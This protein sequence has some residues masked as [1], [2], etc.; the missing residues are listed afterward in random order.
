[1]YRLAIDTGGTFTD[2]C[3]LDE[4]N[5]EAYRCKV[6]ST[7]DDP[8]IAFAAGIKNIL[9]K[10]GVKSDAVSYLGHGTTVGTNSVLEGKGVKTGLVTTKGFRDLLELGR[11]KRPHLYDLQADKPKCLVPRHLRYE[12]EERLD[13]KG[14]VL[15]NL[16]K[17]TL[18]KAFRYFHKEAVEALAIVFLYSFK[19]PEHEK[20]AMRLANDFL[21]NGFLTASYEV[22]PE[23]REY[24]RTSTA[25]MNAFIGPKTASYLN[26]LFDRVKELKLPVEPYI[27]QGNGGIVEIVEA[28][29]F[30][31]RTLLSGPAAGVEGARFISE[32]VG[33]ENIITLDMGGTSTDIAIVSEGREPFISSGQIAGYPLTLPM[34]DISTIGSGG[35]SI[36]RIDSGGALI[37]G[38]ESAGADPGPACYDLGGEDPT[39]TDA[40]VVLGTLNPKALLNGEMQISYKKAFEAIGRIAEKLDTSVEKAAYSI[41]EIGCSNLIRQVYIS[42]A[43]RGLDPRDFTLV[44]FGGAGPLHGPKLAEEMGIKKTLIPTMPGNLSALGILVAD[45]RYEFSVTDIISVEGE[46]VHDIRSTIS[47]LLVQARSWFKKQAIHKDRR[48]IEICF[49]MR[50]VGQNHELIVYYPNSDISGIESNT[51][52]NLFQQKHEQTYGYAKKDGAIQIVNHRVIARGTVSKPS[53]PKRSKGDVNIE[54]A[55]KEY[56]FANI[57]GEEKVNVPVYDRQK[58]LPGHMVKGPAIIEQYDS[59]TYIETERNMSIDNYSNIIIE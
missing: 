49:D 31:V 51:L 45:V 23:F 43:E 1:M 7:P 59:T 29:K 24:E 20:E 15:V 13:H 58:L 40:H 10:Y 3:L 30:P 26:K 53:I 8:S 47:K 50:Y 22:C 6:P 41:F 57:K 36:A 54:N 25:V 9:T 39:I 14:N 42:L 12:V 33:E 46:N 52:K 4:K 37:V 34:L 11:Q 2:I 56:R 38:P 18:E 55:I 16:D 19:N 28:T 32:M 35:G 21:P 5:G 27:V 48:H 44:A 17:P